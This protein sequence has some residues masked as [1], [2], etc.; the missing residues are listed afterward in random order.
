DAAWEG[1][2][3]TE[4]LAPLRDKE[5]T[6][7]LAARRSDAAYHLGRPADALAFARQV[8]GK[9][10]ETLV[11]RLENPPTPRRF[12]LPVPF[13]R[14]HFET[15]A[16]ARLAAVC[17]FWSMPGDHLERAAAITYAGTPNH[18]ERQWAED[19]GWRTR[20]FTVTWDSAVALLDRGVPFTLSTPEPNGSHLQTVVG[21]D[22]VRRTLLLRDPNERHQVEMLG[23]GLQERYRASGPRGMALVP[24]AEGDRLAGLDLP[25]AELYDLRHELDRALEAHR[26]DRAGKAYRSL[27][28]KAAGHPITL[29]ARRTLAA[30]DGDA[31]AELAAVE[32]LLL[33]FPDDLCLQL[34]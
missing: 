17:R 4:R 7:W 28:K 20:E 11:R 14:Q 33:L 23:D 30:Y 24:A 10:Y 27:Q 16:R 5:M 9:F 15:S 31:A 3:E 18:S 21:Y 6:Q 34:A 13:V 32:K 8:K 2:E 26:R 1:L 29:W 12:A 22:A 25:D 19:H